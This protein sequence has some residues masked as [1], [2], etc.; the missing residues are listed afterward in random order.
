MYIYMCVWLCV[1]VTSP[2]CVFVCTYTFVCVCVCVRVFIC[3]CVCFS[4][5]AWFLCV[6]VRACFVCVC[7]NV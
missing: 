3:V 7:I 1:P 5:C 6:H 2:E 4:V